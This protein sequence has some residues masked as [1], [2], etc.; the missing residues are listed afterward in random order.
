MSELVAVENDTDSCDDCHIPPV[1][2]GTYPITPITLQDFVSIGG[3]LVILDNEYFPNHCGAN[4]NATTTLLYID[5]VAVC[6]KGDVSISQ[7]CHTFSGIV[8][9]QQDFV[10]SE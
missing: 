3:K 2:G 10:F 8:V 9:A 1:G 5:G 6:R 4:T 7:D